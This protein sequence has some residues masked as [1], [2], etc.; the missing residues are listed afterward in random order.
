MR[1]IIATLIAA[2]IALIV[3]PASAIAQVEVESTVE[4]GHCS[5][6]TINEETGLP[7]GGCPAHVV[8][9]P[10]TTID[11]L[12][13]TSVGET[14]STGCQHEHD[15]ALG[16]DGEGYFYNQTISGGP[17]CGTT[18][19]ACAAASVQEPWHFQLE[20]DELGSLVAHLETC[21]DIIINAVPLIS[22]RVRADLD[23]DLSGTADHHAAE[24]QNGNEESPLPVESVVAS[25]PTFQ[26]QCNG[27]FAPA[28]GNT[29]ELRG[30]FVTEEPD[31]ID[32]H[33]N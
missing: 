22:C 25:N 10:D 4:E 23:L 16:E 14:L 3:A 7:E 17:F 28:S 31:G 6:V 11:L 19:A 9:A 15:L 27:T 18:I 26:P 30:H 32:V 29:L 1:L 2:A 21:W 20:E 33:H 24:T 13:H 8:N 5:V 12:R